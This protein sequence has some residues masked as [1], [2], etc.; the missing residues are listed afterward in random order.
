MALGIGRTDAA[1]EP[2][3]LVVWSGWFARLARGGVDVRTSGHFA[4]GFEQ[5]HQALG[6]MSSPACRD[7]M[8]GQVTS[9]QVRSR[10][11][12]S[13]HVHGGFGRRAGD[14]ALIHPSPDSWAARGP[15]CHKGF[16]SRLLNQS[17]H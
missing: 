7:G 9:R 4:F 16:L 5:A 17:K 2:V 1:G 12:M 10:H 15:C 11:V 13:C 3:A 6:A 8:S 14:K